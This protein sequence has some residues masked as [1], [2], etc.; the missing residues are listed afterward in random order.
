[1]TTQEKS[2][3]CDNL[4]EKITSGEPLNELEK[5]HLAICECCM[6]QIVT[7]LD[8]SAMRE[9]HGSGAINGD[10]THA[11]PET[12]KALEHG[13]RVFEREFGIS[14]AKE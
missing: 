13:R 1:M 2:R 12:K 5:A 10:L 14:L 8:E 6:T 11:R 7:T 9:T 3:V 4:V